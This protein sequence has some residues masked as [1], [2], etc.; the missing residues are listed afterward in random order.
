[1]YICFRHTSALKQGGQKILFCIKRS[2]LT[3]KVLLFQYIAPICVY[4]YVNIPRI[5]IE[6]ISIETG[7]LNKI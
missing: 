4:I 7:L 6:A 3:L 1:M 2:A 5:N